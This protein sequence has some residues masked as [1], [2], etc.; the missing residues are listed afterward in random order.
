[1]NGDSTWIKQDGFDV[2]EPLTPGAVYELVVDLWSTSLIFKR[3]RLI[4]R[5]RP[6]RAVMIAV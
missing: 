4:S 3:L 1:L 6:G 5:R 2:S